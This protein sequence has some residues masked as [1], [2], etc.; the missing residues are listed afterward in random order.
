MNIQP[1]KTRVFLPNE[2]ILE[3]IKE[4]IYNIKDGDII[5][6]TSKV[7]SYSEGRFVFPYTRKMRDQIIKNESSF[8]LRTKYTWLTIKD[9]MVMASAGVD[10]SNADNKLLLL[11][12]DSFKTASLLR[13]ELMKYYNVKKLGI[14]ITDSRL[15]PLRSG[16]VGV[17]L[18]YA[19][20]KGIRNYIGKRDIF[21]RE[22]KFS[23]TDIADSLAT[24]A[25]LCMGEGNEQQ[26]LATIH[27]AP[28]E[29]INKVNS[30]E[31]KIDPK[32]DLYA[33]LFRA[34]K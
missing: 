18:G 25:V 24:S 12:K 32:E 30:K 28:V 34:L 9:G 22:L 2:N 21:G 16:V 29:Y 33:P 26:P 4:Y 5:V 17:A 20:F 3:F 27:D 6:I 31:L 11:P 1:I 15:L 10:E 8:L 7:V 14:L 13:K 23:R 19:G